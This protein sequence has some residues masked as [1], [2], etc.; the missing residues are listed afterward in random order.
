ML[1]PLFVYNTL[2]DGSLRILNPVVGEEVWSVPGRNQRPHSTT[3]PRRAP[4]ALPPDLDL[5]AVC[6]F[7][8]KQSEHTPAEKSRVV[9]EGAGFRV[10]EKQTAEQALARPALFRR[11]PNL[12]EIVPM[13]FWK[14]NYGFK[15]SP[16]QR[17][18]KEAYLSTPKGRE[19]ILGV[20][21]EKLEHQG[22]GPE[23]IAA[24]S[25]DAKFEMADAFFGGSHDLIV[26]GR[27]YREGATTEADLLSSGALSREEHFLFL[28]FT[29]NAVGELHRE[30]PY[31]KHVAVYQNWLAQ[32]GASFDHLH[33]Q[34][35]GVD[36]WGA[37]IHRRLE[38]LRR[39][40]PFYNQV[41]LAALKVRALV[42]A[43]N[44]HAVAVVE[45]GHIYPCLGVY[46]KS[47]ASDPAGLS[48]EELRGFSDLLRAVHVAS[49]SRVPCNE[50]WY[51]R[52][53]GSEPPM[54]FHV[55]LK[56]RVNI[57]AGFEGGSEIHIN[58]LFPEQMRDRVLPALKELAARGEM[59]GAQVGED[60]PCED[61]CLRYDKAPQR[62]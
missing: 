29:L 34:I 40:P 22:R 36:T 10:L 24:F 25:E 52:P 46:S 47:A 55:L 57:P 9:R 51:F 39:F 45:P 62:R 32:A 37:G 28:S 26:S 42:L 7:C 60:C 8:A 1:K 23:E 13:E 5:D 43:E 17:Q 50:E 61:G 53:R 2:A 14:R 21:D 48:P 56:W 4:Q 18:W 44:A 49:G 30:N 58:P 11:V 54:P 38:V 41:L 35:L 16:L 6:H 31:I 59:P 33:K 27:H 15:L 20:I 19:H 12:F 3:D